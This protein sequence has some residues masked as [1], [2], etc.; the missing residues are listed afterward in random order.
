[1]TRMR[2]MPPFCSS[3]TT[4]DAPASMAF[5]INSF[6]TLAGRSTTSPAAIRSATWGE[7]CWI[8]GMGSPPYSRKLP[9]GIRTCIHRR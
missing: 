4:A 8:W 9:A 5:S 7:S 3:T 2:D 1:M 6:T